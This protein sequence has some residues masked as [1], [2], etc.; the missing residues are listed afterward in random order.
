[1]MRKLGSS[2]VDSHV[3]DVAVPA[4]VRSFS[5][6]EPATGADVTSAADGDAWMARVVERVSQRDAANDFFVV[7]AARHM[8]DNVGSANATTDA[9]DEAF[10]NA[11]VF[12]V[13]RAH[14][15]L[16]PVCVRYAPA[17]ANE[18]DVRSAGSR[19][20]SGSPL[21]TV[22][23]HSPL[24]VSSPAGIQ[25]QR[26]E[27]F[28][29]VLTA[30]DCGSVV[31]TVDGEAHD[32]QCVP[33]TY[34]VLDLVHSGV[35]LTDE[36]VKV[37]GRLMSEELRKQAAEALAMLGPRRSNLTIAEAELHA[38]ILDLLNWNQKDVRF[39]TNFGRDFE[40]PFSTLS[41]NS[42][43]LILACCAGP[44]HAL[45]IYCV[46]GP[47]WSEASGWTAYALVYRHHCVPM[48]MHD[49]KFAGEK[50][51]SLFLRHALA[52]GVAPIHIT[53][54]S[55]QEAV[56]CS[57]ATD[58]AVAGGVVS[59]L[60]FPADVLF[61]NLRVDARLHGLIS[62]FRL[63][64][65]LAPLRAGRT[66]RAAA[67]DLLTHRLAPSIKK[68]V[69]RWY[70]SSDESDDSKNA[71]TSVPAASTDDTRASSSFAAEHQKELQLKHIK[72]NGVL[73]DYYRLIKCQLTDY[74]RAISVLCSG[75][76]ECAY[77][78][79]DFC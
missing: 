56:R 60:V 78:I 24:N 23:P 76:C 67:L 55:W 49:G 8:A 52:F 37:R 57:L 44:G 64:E 34:S 32:Y 33:I 58:A 74:F 65:A 27:L 39:V 16:L 4:P 11:M 59:D 3:A 47:A 1:M 22:G 17:S 26:V 45:R 25:T 29:A 72:E 12:G 30:L 19:A 66:A 13:E 70:G 75:E 79:L 28:G 35:T 7:W 9:V 18:R 36:L 2:R 61:N 63:N 77:F 42:L 38:D 51:G 71:P 21:L 50:G 53:A 40:R 68:W 62:G 10:R 14:R 20:G 46:T 48:R 5:T 54:R 31:V 41:W 15:T 69:N 73:V 43:R 6:D